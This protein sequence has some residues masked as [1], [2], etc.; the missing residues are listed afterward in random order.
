LCVAGR[1]FDLYNYDDFDFDVIDSVI[2][3]IIRI[4]GF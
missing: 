4:A 1:A 2:I 3:N